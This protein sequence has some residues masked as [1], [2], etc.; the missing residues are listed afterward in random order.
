MRG[1]HSGAHFINAKMLRNVC[2]PNALQHILSDWVTSAHEKAIQ[3][4]L[5]CI[6][7][8]NNSQDLLKI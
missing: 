4:T 8:S 6:W 5:P 7:N 2:L 3:L 1:T